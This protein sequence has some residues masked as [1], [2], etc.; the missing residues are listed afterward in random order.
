MSECRSL[1]GCETGDAKVTKGYKLSARYVIHTV[2]PVW[3]GGKRQE[4]ELLASCYRRSLEEASELG[5]ET[6]AFPAISCGV[7]GFPPD[8]AAPIAVGEICRFL[9]SNALPKKVLLVAYDDRM[10]EI[11]SG[12]L[13]SGTL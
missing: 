12:A 11:L 9:S 8:L 1:N 6:I 2:G 10:S 5:I 13:E 3:S 4:R 7:Y